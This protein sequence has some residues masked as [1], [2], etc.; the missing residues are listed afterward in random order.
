MPGSTTKTISTR[1]KR[2]KQDVKSRA[3]PQ[4][5]SF[6]LTTVVNAFDFAGNSQLFYALFHLREIGIVLIKAA[7][8]ISVH[9]PTV[10]MLPA[11]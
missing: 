7:G 10:A 1:S 9:F 3:S 5:Q 4:L 11:E 8:V 2:A 6:W